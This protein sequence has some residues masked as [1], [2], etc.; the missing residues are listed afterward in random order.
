[1]E[2]CYLHPDNISDNIDWAGVK[3][4]LG[5]AQIHGPLFKRGF[6]YPQCPFTFHL[7]DGNSQIA[8]E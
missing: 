5:N 2:R 7:L 4:Y 1:M 3:S 8:I 6:P